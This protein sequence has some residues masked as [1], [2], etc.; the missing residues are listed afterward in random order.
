MC[1]EVEE[2]RVDDVTEI[3]VSVDAAIA[4]S[5]VHT[6]TAAERVERLGRLDNS[7]EDEVE[8]RDEGEDEDEDVDASVEDESVEDEESEEDIEGDIEED[9]EP[10][11]EIED[12]GEE[13][14]EEEDTKGADDGERETGEEEEAEDDTECDTK[15]GSRLD[16]LLDTFCAR[17]TDLACF[18]AG[19]EI[20]CAAP[21]CKIRAIIAWAC[22]A[23][24]RLR[25]ATDTAWSAMSFN[26]RMSA[27]VTAALAPTREA[28]RRLSDAITSGCWSVLAAEAFCSSTFGRFGFCTGAGLRF[29]HLRKCSI[30]PST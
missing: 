12:E 10:I 7:K 15:I 19:I 17:D 25:W 26:F 27:A 5:D 30:L 2:E 28:H 3:E 4:G 11:E 20:P 16:E 1:E 18:F 6:D 8:G 23:F 22:K 29:T 13:E 9:K 24:S 14:E 21:I